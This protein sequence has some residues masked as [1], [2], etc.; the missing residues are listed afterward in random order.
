MVER[1]YQTEFIGFDLMSI[2]ALTLR[3]GD[4]EIPPGRQLFAGEKPQSPS[5]DE[6]AA[7]AECI[8]TCVKIRISPLPR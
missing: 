4:I 8:V 1:L 2:S 6:I 7:I 5:W 3:K